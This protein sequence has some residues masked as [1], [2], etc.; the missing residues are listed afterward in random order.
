MQHQVQTAWR[1]LQHAASRHLGHCLDPHPA[2]AI[3]DLGAMQLHPGRQVAVQVHQC[4]RPVTT[5]GQPAIGRRHRIA[6][7]RC[8][9]PA[10]LQLQAG[11][12]THS[13][14]ITPG[15]LLTMT[16]D[17]QRQTHKQ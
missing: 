9:H 15:A 2:D 12:G 11:I 5:V 8:P 3:D 13:R 7:H 4:D 1:Q 14:S 6:R 17:Q 16:A 10:L